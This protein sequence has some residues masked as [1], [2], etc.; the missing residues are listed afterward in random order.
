MGKKIIS[1]FCLKTKIIFTCTRNILK[2]IDVTEKENPVKLCRS[3][4]GL[5]DCFLKQESQEML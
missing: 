4:T 1:L 5:E 3:I 2:V